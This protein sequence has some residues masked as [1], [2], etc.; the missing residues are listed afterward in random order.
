VL[1]GPGSSVGIATGYGLDGPGIESRLEARFSA[2]V[3]TGPGAH[4][5]SCTMGTGSFP[6]IMRRG[7]AGDHSPPSS[8]VVMEE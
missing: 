7:R 6:E 1:D 8:A 2:P 4:P 3:Q 5:A